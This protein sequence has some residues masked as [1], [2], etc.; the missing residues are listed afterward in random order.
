MDPSLPRLAPC[1]SG[2]TLRVAETPP[3]VEARALSG[4]PERA[5]DDLVALGEELGAEL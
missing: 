2:M 5:R 3:G 4:R 1:V